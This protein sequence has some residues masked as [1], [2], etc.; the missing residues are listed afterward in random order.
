MHT[1]A[2]KTKCASSISSHYFGLEFYVMSNLY[3]WKINLFFCFW[4]ESN[5][6][7]DCSSTEQVSDDGGELPHVGGKQPNHDSDMYAIK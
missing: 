3:M 7:N 2:N 4:G 5:K 6:S 1:E